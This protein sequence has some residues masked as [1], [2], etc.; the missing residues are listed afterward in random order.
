MGDLSAHFSRVE[1]DCKDG[2]HAH[3][4]QALI[5]ALEKLRAIIGKPI[6]IVSGYRT[7]EYN[8]RVGGAKQSR[9]MYNDAADIS[10]FL[11]VT[12]AQ[13][14]QAGFTGIGKRDDGIVVHVD[15]RPRQTP[16][17]FRDHA[18]Y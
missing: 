14:I 8:A 7:P 5:L 15:M 10:R 3:P 12:V 18:N 16:L 4:S 13:A 6:P 2:T 9:H 11:R 1:F 17:V